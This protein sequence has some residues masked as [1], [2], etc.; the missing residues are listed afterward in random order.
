[1]KSDSA[2]LKGGMLIS[3]FTLVA[4]NVIPLFYT[5]YVVKTLGMEEFGVYSLAKS[6]TDFLVLLNLG[7]SAGV[8]KF[9][10]QAIAEKDYEARDNIFTLSVY[11]FFA[12]FL[13]ILLVGS[14]AS[15]NAVSIFGAIPQELHPKL[16]I[17]IGVVTLTTAFSMFFSVYTAVIQAHQRFIFAKL[18]SLLVTAVVPLVSALLLW[19]GYRS[20]GMVIGGAV[21]GFLYGVV[22]VIYGHWVLRVRFVRTKLD[23]TPLKSMFHFSKYI[24][25]GNIATMLYAATDKVILGIYASA[26][27]VAVYS[28]GVTFCM[29]L[30]MVIRSISNLLF[31]K[32]NTM[33]AQGA[34]IAELD[35]VILKV[36]RLQYILLSPILS[37][38]IVFGDHFIDLWLGAGYESAYWI[39]LFMMI[40]VSIPLLQNCGLSVLKALNRHAF[41]SWILCFIAILNAIGS[42]FAVQQWGVVGCAAVTCVSYFIGPVIIMNIYYR[43]KIELDIASFW[44]SIFR[45][46]G[47]FI[48]MLGSGLALK[49]YILDDTWMNFITVAGC[50]SLLYFIILWYTG[51]NRYEKELMLGLLSKLNWRRFNT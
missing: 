34:S 28:V 17:L 51:M 10:N 15:L 19:L 47:A 39:A 8:L 44:K 36:G 33:L 20:V 21:I 30:E 5:P 50:F 7:F 31:P 6:I 22:H 35:S 11:C 38:F 2:Q 24:L 16:R 9:I 27:A 49:P 42:V 41:R 26:A 12:I 25:L 18:A 45:M 14:V 29:Y 13:V 3:Y 48:V 4:G 43:V 40:P 23:T 37:G 32:I 46:S 1:M